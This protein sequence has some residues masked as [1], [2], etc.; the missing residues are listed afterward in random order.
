MK[1]IIV[2]LLTLSLASAFCACTKQE[3]VPAEESTATETE[4]T[5]ETAENSGGV[6]LIESVDLTEENGEA[7]AEKEPLSADFQALEDKYTEHYDAVL[8]GITTYAAKMMESAE[9]IASSVG[10]VLMYMNTEDTKAHLTAM[11]EVIAEMET[12]AQTDVDRE[13]IE[14]DKAALKIYKD[15]QSAYENW[16]SLE[17][18]KQQEVMAYIMAL[19]MSQTSAE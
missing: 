7:V 16:D 11:D 9:G 3:A 19:A 17:S 15:I 2:L 18:E 4:K 14:S 13:K 5:E 8:S 10:E 12:T 1:K 6:T